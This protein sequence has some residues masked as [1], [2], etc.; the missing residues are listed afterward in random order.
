MPSKHG[1]R[2]MDSP[3]VRGDLLATLLRRSARRRLTLS[4]GRFAMIDNGLGFAL[5]T[6]PPRTHGWIGATVGWGRRST[7]APSTSK[8]AAAC[9]PSAPDNFRANP[10]ASALIYVAWTLSSLPVK[11]GVRTG[12]RQSRAP[13]DL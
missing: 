7:Q 13:C 8:K 12:N 5:T 3:V 6:S 1:P 9:L 4:S 11:N 2:R 10:I